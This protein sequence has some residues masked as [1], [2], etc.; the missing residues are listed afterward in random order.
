[1]LGGE[2]LWGGRPVVIGGDNLPSPV[3]KGLND[4]PNMGGGQCPPP[5]G[6]FITDID[7]SMIAICGLVKA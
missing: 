5:L 3:E 6:S 7:Q 4:L 2:K 1:M